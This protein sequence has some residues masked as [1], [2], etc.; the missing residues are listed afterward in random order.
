LKRFARHSDTK[1]IDVPRRKKMKF[2]TKNL[3]AAKNECLLRASMV[4]WR[5]NE[6]IRH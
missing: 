5:R 2:I 1:I 3:Q 6:K 4:K